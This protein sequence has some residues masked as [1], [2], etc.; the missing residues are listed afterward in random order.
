MIRTRVIALIFA[1]AAGAITV[2]TSAPSQAAP[3]ELSLALGRA[4]AAPGVAASRTAALA[5]DL[6]TG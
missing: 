4:L 5:V 6:E 1:V 2:T 3:P